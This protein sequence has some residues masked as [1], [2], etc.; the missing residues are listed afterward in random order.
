MVRMTAG[1]N[2]RVNKPAVSAFGLRAAGL[3]MLLFIIGMAG[4]QA[5]INDYQI[6]RLILYQTGCKLDSVARRPAAG[7]ALNFLVACQNLSFYPDGVLIEC[8]DG[9]DATTCKVRTQSRSFDL[10]M[11]QRD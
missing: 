10:K 5:G 9:D 6:R 1:R 4:V 2:Q 3:I 7:G 11:L 8:D